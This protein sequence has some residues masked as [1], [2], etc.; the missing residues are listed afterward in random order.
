MFH[1]LLVAAAAAAPAGFKQVKQSDGCTF[2][3]GPADAEGVQP[4][5]VECL[6]PDVPYERIDR[7]LSDFEHHDDLHA[8]IELAEVVGRTPE[9]RSLV[10]QVHVAPAISDRELVAVYWRTTI[11]DGFQIHWDMAPDQP[12][13]QDGNV[14]PARMRGT[15]TVT[16]VGAGVKAVYDLQYGAGGSVPGF[17]IRW[18]QT[19]GVADLVQEVHEAA[20]GG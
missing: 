1:W 8:S 13:V 17:V 11:P 14:L 19:S 5:H 18:F 16:R 10:H 12:P 3:V 4:V 20:R 6:W 15:W 2:F 9:G 7:L